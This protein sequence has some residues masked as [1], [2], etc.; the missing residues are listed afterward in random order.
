MSLRLLKFPKNPQPPRR[1]PTLTPTVAR[2][3]PK[4]RELN[5]QTSSRIRGLNV[6]LADE[7]SIKIIPAIVLMVQPHI[8]GTVPASTVQDSK[9]SLN[10]V[11]PNSGDREL[12]LGIRIPNPVIQKFRQAR[13]PA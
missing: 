10:A 5:N 9:P 11:L 1:V 3:L 13:H 2:L 6:M 8:Q 4:R 7:K 12:P